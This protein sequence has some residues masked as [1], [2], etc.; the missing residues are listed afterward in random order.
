MSV[1]QI[2]LITLA[3][4]NLIGL[5]LCL[6]TNDE[7]I[8]SIWAAGIWAIP[9][10]LIYLTKRAV[11]TIDRKFFRKCIVQRKPDARGEFVQK[12]CRFKDM[13]Y[14]DNSNFWT[15]IKKKPTAAELRVGYSST[16]SKGETVIR[17]YAPQKVTEDEL[18][19]VKTEHNCF[20]CI[21]NGS[22]CNDDNCLCSWESLKN[23][24][25]DHFEG[26]C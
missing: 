18:N 17:V 5:L 12:V 11:Q 6:F 24:T 23:Y 19:E 16:N 26:K 1:W 3:V 10:L 14:F 25:N 8:V 15:V 4:Y 7:D 20:N 21:H 22:D 9:L 2:V 13:E